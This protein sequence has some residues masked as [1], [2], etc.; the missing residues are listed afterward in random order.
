MAMTTEKR[1][2]LAEHLGED[3]DARI[4][5]ELAAFE[6]QLISAGVRHKERDTALAGLKHRADRGDHAAP[7]IIDLLTKGVMR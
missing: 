1:R 4:E 7:Y 2:F 5:G 6:E 3:E